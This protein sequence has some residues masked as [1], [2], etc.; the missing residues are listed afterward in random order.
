MSRSRPGSTSF[1][2]NG[3]FGRN[4][5]PKP[6]DRVWPFIDYDND[7]WPDIFLVNGTGLAA[8][9]Y[10]AEVTSFEKASE[11]R[12]ANDSLWSAQ[13]STDRFTVL[14]SQTPAG[15]YVRNMVLSSRV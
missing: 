4:I 3:A 2:N 9:F 11:R 6:W 1:H 10:S 8:T 7:G 13:P 14:E 12:D 15:L 5:L